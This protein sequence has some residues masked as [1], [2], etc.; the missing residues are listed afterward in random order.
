MSR[1]KESQ[2]ISEWKQLISPRLT[3]NEYREIRSKYRV[4]KM[5][6]ITAEELIRRAKTNPVPESFPSAVTK[7][8][9]VYETATRDSLSNRH[10]CR[11]VRE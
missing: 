2:L 4:E 10:G 9:P 3:L 11:G 6:R 7:A 8:N 5:N 1:I